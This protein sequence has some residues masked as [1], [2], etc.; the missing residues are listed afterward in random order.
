MTPL[1][2]AISVLSGLPL[3]TAIRVLEKP[4]FYEPLALA[5]EKGDPEFSAELAKIVEDMLAD[6]TLS[7]LSKQWLGQDYTKKL[8][9]SK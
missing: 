4:I 1:L 3:S 6:G 5:I 8:T 7:R 9:I 2:W